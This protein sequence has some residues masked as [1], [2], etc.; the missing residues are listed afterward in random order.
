VSP[1][2]WVTLEFEWQI[3][4]ILFIKFPK[5]EQNTKMPLLCGSLIFHVTPFVTLRYRWYERD[6]LRRNLHHFGQQ[7]ALI[8][9]KN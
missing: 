1:L 4:E 8:E 5:S 7:I 2:V 9:L 3:V 6:M